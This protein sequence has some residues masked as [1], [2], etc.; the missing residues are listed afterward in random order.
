MCLCVREN[1]IFR[2]EFF[3]VFLCVRQYFFPGS[4]NSYRAADFKFCTA[5][6]RR[7]ILKSDFLQNENENFSLFLATFGKILTSTSLILIR[8][9]SLSYATACVLIF[10]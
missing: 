1:V 5:E 7:L 10:V 8:H 3:V 6:K 2:K 4:E 9:S